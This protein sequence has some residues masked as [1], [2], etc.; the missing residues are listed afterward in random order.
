M[1]LHKNV[2]VKWTNKITKEEVLKTAEKIKI[3]VEKH[4]GKKGSVNISHFNTLITGR[5]QL[6][7]TL[8]IIKDVGDTKFQEIKIDRG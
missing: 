7:Y 6:D 1:Q 4:N 2:K 8:Q 5:P 3:T